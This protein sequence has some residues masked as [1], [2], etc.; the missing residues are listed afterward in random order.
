MNQKYIKVIMKYVIVY[1]TINI[2]LGVSW[3]NRFSLETS[4][5][6][7]DY[8]RDFVHVRII[9]KSKFYHEC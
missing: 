3:L 2:K 4:F 6:D 8:N 5:S 7:A 9:Q 1:I